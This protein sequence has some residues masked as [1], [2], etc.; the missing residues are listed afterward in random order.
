MQ[1]DSELIG[2]LHYK[3]GHDLYHWRTGWFVL[4]GSAL[5]FSPGEGD[6]EEEVLHLK[7]LQELSKNAAC[8]RCRISMAD[9]LSMLESAVLARNIRQ[10]YHFK[11][12]FVHGQHSRPP[13][14]FPFPFLKGR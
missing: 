1:K 11:T 2:R 8:R 9:C 12:L 14:S 7:Q 4:R 13:L 3:E 5:H 10:S 6:A